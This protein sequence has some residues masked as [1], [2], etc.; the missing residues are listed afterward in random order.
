[1]RSTKH[2]SSNTLRA[3]PRTL[4]QNGKQLYEPGRPIPREKTHTQSRKLVGHRAYPVLHDRSCFSSGTSL[5]AVQGELAREEFEAAIHEFPHEVAPN[6][7]LGIALELEE[8]QQVPS[9]LL[10]PQSSRYRR[11]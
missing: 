4:S 9:L 7:F 5:K 8:Q 2:F 10:K 6:K 3:S 1:M 11:V